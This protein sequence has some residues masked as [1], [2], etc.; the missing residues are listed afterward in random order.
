MRGIGVVHRVAAVVMAGGAIALQPAR[1]A[2]QGKLELTPF[3]TSYYA[4]S[5]TMAYTEDIPGVGTLTFDVNQIAGPGLGGRLTYWLPNGVGI[6]A[7]GSYLFSNVRVLVQDP[8]D[9]LTSGVDQSLKG[10]IVSATGRVLYRLPRSNFHMFAGAG[11]V[12]RGGEIW[13]DL[14]SLSDF[15]GLVGFG[16]RAAVTPK[17]AL[18]VKV[19]AQIY[20][21]NTFKKLFE[22]P[23]TGESIV[24]SKMQTDIHVSLGIPIALI[25]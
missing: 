16:A 13:Q 4:L 1:V 17:L 21:F 6:E 12:Q 18:D 7:T 2:A 14:P 20:T 22:D 9:T 15:T 23:N 25:K 3:F 11:I 10:N 8:T 5:K 19:E 24:D